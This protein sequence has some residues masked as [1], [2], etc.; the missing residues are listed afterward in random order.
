MRW[1]RLPDLQLLLL[2]ALARLILHLLTSGQYGFH[3]DELATLDDA[4]WLAWG[5]VA[6]PPLTPFVARL[7][8]ELFGPSL[9]GLRLFSAAAQCGGL[10]LA[11]L[12]ARELGGG[13][14]AQ[15]V[16]A[17]AVTS[18]PISLIQGALFQYV[19]FDYLWWV[20]I[21]W[22]SLRLLNSSNP[23]WWLA[24]GLAAGLGLLTKYTIAFLLVGL[25]GGLLI[26]P[27]RQQLTGRWLWTGLALAVLIWLPNLLWQ[28]QHSFVSLEFLSAIHSR[29]VRIGRTQGYLPEQLYVNASP[30][31]IPLWIA[32]LWFYLIAP[33]GQRYRLLGWLYVIPGLLC[34]AAQARAYYLGPAYPPLLAAG[35]VVVERWLAAGRPG[36][37]R[38]GRA[39]TALVLAS[40]IVASA[41][42]SLPIAPVNSGLWSLTSKV[43]DNFVEE[44]GWPELVE[45]VA[46]L[47]AALPP[48]SQPRAAILAG[49]YGEAGA[50]DLYG[51]AYGLPPA[52]SGVDSYWLRGYPEPPPQT[53]IVLGYRRDEVSAVFET[54]DPAARV[55]NR[56]GVAN[57]ETANFPEIFVCRAPRQPWSVLWPSLRRFN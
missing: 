30:L 56:Y 48:D 29:D 6:Y 53:T 49:N 40:A 54:C 35:A 36:R 51:P 44:I 55:T 5:Y 16:T 25:A 2:L 7:A 45:T 24:I 1:P 52:L 41:A 20:L 3:R 4:R 50:I 15:V 19:S 8:L 47:Y 33:A 14:W 10:V 32:G 23:R 9:V 31:T 21:A 37:A 27:L 39:C 38:L 18:A 43:H 12:I 26:T 46:G 42:L 34:L 22:C 57:E 28:A 11:G 17:L 13:R